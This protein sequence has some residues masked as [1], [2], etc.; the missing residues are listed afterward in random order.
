VLTR[1]LRERATPVVVAG[2]WRRLE[3]QGGDFEA[4]CGTNPPVADGITVVLR[5]LVPLAQVQVLYG[6]QERCRQD[7]K[8]KLDTLRRLCHRLRTGRIRTLFDLDLPRLERSQRWFVMTA[9]TAIVRAFSLDI[10]CAQSVGGDAYLIQRQ[11][12]RR[13]PV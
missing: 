6:I 5:E 11:A 9:Q 7:L 10:S 1:W 13:L 4:F 12:R 3:L 2:R 8:T